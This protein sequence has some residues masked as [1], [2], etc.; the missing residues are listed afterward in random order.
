MT[1]SGKRFRPTLI[2]TVVAIAGMILLCTLGFWQLQRYQYKKMLLTSYQAALKANPE[3]FQQALHQSNKRFKQVIVKGIFLNARN[4]L[5]DNRINHSRVGYEVITPLLVSGTNKVLLVNRGWIPHNAGRQQ[6]PSIKPVFGEQRLTGYIKLADKH[7]F[8]LGS[9]VRTPGQWPLL[10]QKIDFKVLDQ[11]IKKP[12]YPFVVRLDATAANGFVR[13]WQPI[14][15]MPQ[16]H[17]GYALQWFGLAIVLLL[18]FIFFSRK[19]VCE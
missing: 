14:N 6:L 1:G 8:I 11:A 4:I 7:H 9:N 18:T 17:L 10:I 5:L 15:V 12:L 2:A 19:K 16:R 13:N 3:S